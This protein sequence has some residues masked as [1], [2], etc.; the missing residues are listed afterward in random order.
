MTTIGIWEIT[1][2]GP[3]RAT[4]TP[5][6][7]EA[8]LEDWIAR[9]LTLVEPGLVLMGRQLKLEAGR[10]D[11][12][13][14]DQQG[15]WVV[16][17]VKREL[18]YRE[19]VAQA[20]DYAACI[21]TLSPEEIRTMASPEL[22]S[23]LKESDTEVEALD[24]ERREV[25]VL[26]VGV[27]RTPGLDRL[28]TYLGSK[29]S[30]PISIISFDTF[31]VGGVRVLAR[32]V[33]ETQA[34]ADPKPNASTV[35]VQDVI[36][37]AE[38]GGIATTLS[39]FIS[40][41]DELGLH[42]R[43]WKHCLMLAAPTRRTKTLV[44]VWAVPEKGKIK[45]YVQTSAFVEFLGVPEATAKQALGNDGTR[46]FAPAECDDLLSRIRGLVGPVLS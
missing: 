32:E 35:Q 34:A 30:V 38:S 3:R 7:S 29:F 9:D 17:E 46:H 37:R 45:V 33:F 39:Q 4:G 12:L 21:A 14:I 15:R 25:R 44:T 42:V 40:L 5:P 18:L 43:P 16:I 2:E 36:A 11:L 28:V 1:S 19:A 13:A 26:V 10:L 41:A 8:E 20:L 6:K 24:L 27:G 22:D 31:S 23:F